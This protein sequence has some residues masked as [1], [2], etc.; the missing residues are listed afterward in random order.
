MIFG[1]FVPKVATNGEFL[2]PSVECKVLDKSV[3]HPYGARPEAIQS[4]YLSTGSTVHPKYTLWMASDLTPYGWDTL[5]SNTLHST[6]GPKNSPFGATLAKNGQNG[7]KG[8]YP[9]F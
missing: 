5:F 1:L 3:F 9:L 6:E 2:G 4:V 7:S 8:G